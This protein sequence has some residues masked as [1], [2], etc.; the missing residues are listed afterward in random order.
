MLSAVHEIL[1]SGHTYC[2]IHI[3]TH[4][5]VL[6]PRGQ[7]N[8]IVSGREELPYTSRDPRVDIAM[9]IRVLRIARAH[10][11]IIIWFHN[12]QQLII[13]DN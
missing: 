3:Y 4:K 6:I 5:Q 9:G 1:T 8:F 10:I 13:D 11:E 12:H 7:N 2:H